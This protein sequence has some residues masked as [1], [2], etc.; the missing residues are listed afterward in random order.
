MTDWIFGI[1][2]SLFGLLGAVLAAGAMDDGMLTF[3]LG[4]VAFAVVLVFWLIKDRFDEQ[5]RAQL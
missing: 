5:E 4:L 2:V 1:V 3:G